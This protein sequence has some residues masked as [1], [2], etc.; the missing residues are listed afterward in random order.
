MTEAEIAEKIAV[1]QESVEG[2]NRERKGLGYDS[3]SLS[4]G[5]AAFRPG[6]DGSFHDVFVRADEEMYQKKLRFH[7]V[8]E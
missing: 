7:H 1:M 6:L 4:E 5:F 2:Y 3:L 8:R